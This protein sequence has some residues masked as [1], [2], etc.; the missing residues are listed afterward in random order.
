MQK[1]LFVLSGYS[2][3][4]IAINDSD[5]KKAARYSRVLIVTELVL[6]GTQCN[7]LHYKRTEGS[8]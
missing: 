1:K 3:F 2:L 7:E 6:S 8:F 5:A 4:N